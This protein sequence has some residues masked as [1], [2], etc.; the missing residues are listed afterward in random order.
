MTLPPLSDATSALIEAPAKAV[1]A[2]HGPAKG[3][4]EAESMLA[5]AAETGPLPEGSHMAELLAAYRAAKEEIDLQC[6]KE[7]AKVEER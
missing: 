2:A 6:K 3:M 1:A 5:V 4:L 7:R